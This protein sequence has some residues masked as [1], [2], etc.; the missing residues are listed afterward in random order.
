MPRNGSGQYIPTTSSWNPATNG[1]SATA[2]DWNGLLSDLSAALTGSV[3]SD[4]ETPMTGNLQMGNN[5]VTGM[6]APTV[7]GDGVRYDQLTKGADIASASTITIPSEGSYFLV[8]GSTA[9]TAINTVYSGRMAFLKFAAGI[10]LTNSSNLIMPGGQNVTTLDGDVGA[11]VNESVGVWRCLSYVKNIPLPIQGPAFSAYAATNQSVSSGVATKVVF[12]T[13]DFDTNSN[14][15]SS[16]FTPTVAG[17]YQVNANLYGTYSTGYDGSLRGYIYKNGSPVIIGQDSYISPNV[18][19]IGV[20]VTGL[21]YLNGTTDYL[22][23]YGV[24]NGTGIQYSATNTYQ[25]S[26]FSASLVRSA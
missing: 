25:T 23:I 19:I 8:T 12:G 10:V 26:R 18:S 2:A 1:N 3:A 17:Y 14:F 15:A 5:K 13:E 7:S 4:G 9:I 22:E 24:F 16:T 20:V 21:V 11:F 6:A